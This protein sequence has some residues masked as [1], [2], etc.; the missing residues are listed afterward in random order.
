[1]PYFVL[2]TKD[3]VRYRIPFDQK[4]HL[5]LFT[6]FENLSFPLTTAIFRG[7]NLGKHLRYIPTYAYGLGLKLSGRVSKIQLMFVI[8]Y[9]FA[10]SHRVGRYLWP[11]L[12]WPD[13]VPSD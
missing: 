13:L 8:F 4:L 9:F 6:L 7:R 3:V 5:E 11:S 2:Q 12:G 1:M 10:L